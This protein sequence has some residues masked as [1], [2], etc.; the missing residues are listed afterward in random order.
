[1]LISD[2]VVCLLVGDHGETA[3]RDVPGAAQLSGPL[4]RAHAIANGQYNYAIFNYLV[5]KN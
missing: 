3:A 4:I 5:Y 1:M 2:V